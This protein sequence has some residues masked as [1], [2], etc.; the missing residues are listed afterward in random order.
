MDD[1]FEEDG[2]QQYVVQTKSTPTGFLA[3]VG[4][5]VGLSFIYIIFHVFCLPSWK[6]LQAQNLGAGATGDGGENNNNDEEPEDGEVPSD[7]TGPTMSDT[8]D[9]RTSLLSQSRSAV[10]AQQQ[11]EQ[12]ELQHLLRPDAPPNAVEPSGVQEQQESLQNSAL[13][14]PSSTTDRASAVPSTTSSARRRLPRQSTADRPIRSWDLSSMRWKHRGPLSRLQSVQRSVQDERRLQLSSEEGGSNASRSR[15]SWNSRPGSRIPQHR[16]ASDLA[17]NVLDQGN[18][19]GEAQFYRQRYMERNASRQRR[20]RGS[21][22]S[23][24]RS[25]LPGL[26]P[27]AVSP[28]EAADAHDPG[29]LNVGYTYDLNDNGAGGNCLDCCSPIGNFLDYSD[30]DFET[31][32]ILTLAFPATIEAVMDPFFRMGVVALL[33]H[34]LDTDSM[35]AFLLVSL[36]VRTSTEELSGALA[37]AQS[38]LLQEAIG[39]GGNIGFTL[40]GRFIQLGILMQLL[41]VVPF[42]TVWAYFMED[43]VSWFVS[44]NYDIAKTASDYAQIIAIEFAIRA[45]NRSFML[46]FHMTGLAQFE[47]NVDLSMTALTIALIAVAASISDDISLKGIAWIQVIIAAASTVGKVTYMW[48]KGILKAYQEGLS[49]GLVILDWQN[50]KVY[51]TIMFPLLLGSLVEVGEWEVLILFVQHMGGAE[52]ATWA[53]M[54]IVWEV[55]EAFTE[56]LGEASAVRV[57]YYLTENLPVLS[58]QL[59]HKAVFLSIME[60]TILT[61][62][63]LLIGP[64]LAVAL[65][66]DAVLQHLFND[67]VPM[68]ALA[69][70]AMS[71]AQIWWSLVGAQ[72]YF[73]R[74]SAVILANRWFLIIPLSCILIYPASYDL[75]GVAA[76]ITVG[77]TCAGTLLA[78]LVFQSDWAAAARQYQEDSGG[79]DPGLAIESEQERDEGADDEEGEEESEDDSSTGFG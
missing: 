65:T 64:N 74:A 30:L 27:D 73:S 24:V 1:S 38:T 21:S 71:L 31:R 50:T 40:A 68:V 10:A 62:I 45:V 9:N 22:A 20:S 11:Q 53:M 23:S 76:A 51:L 42:L 60:S 4:C 43:I 6:T 77:H 63:F 28:D 5:L 46:A 8:A 35:V 39:Q 72:G 54:G 25:A 2:F 52:V 36:L 58:E 29:T 61:A 26:S 56:G 47:L 55:F 79:I 34:F 17:S 48:R 3:A 49:G 33:S 69:N 66:R 37:D 44:E 14:R 75:S 7:G 32:R 16:G 18:V 70:I 13:H 67:L 19:E 59:A 57:T 12:E 15:S 41:L 78:R